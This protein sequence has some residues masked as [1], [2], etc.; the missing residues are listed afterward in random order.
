MS[1]PVD[2][3]A[4]AFEALSARLASGEITQAQHDAIAL[5]SIPGLVIGAL[6]IIAGVSGLRASR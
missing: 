1:T 3:G 5:Q 2:P 4:A 6:F